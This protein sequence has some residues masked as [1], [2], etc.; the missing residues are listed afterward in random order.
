MNLTQLRSLLR[1]DL[2]DATP[3]DQRWEDDTL[4]RHLRRATAEYSLAVPWQLTLSVDTVPGSR[5]IDITSISSRVGISAVEYPAGQ[6]P[7]A[8]RR[9]ADR[10]DT[11][12]IEDGPVP[13][14]GTALIHYGVAH[15]LDDAGTT[16]PE[17]HH[18]ILLAGASAYSAIEWAVHAVNRVNT[19]ADV[20]GG[21]FRWG[22]ARLAYFQSALKTLRCGRKV[23]VGYAYNP[24]GLVS[25]FAPYLL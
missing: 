16:V 11:L 3:A 8:F 7:R 2:G 21:Y 19:G 20:A 14:G 1:L 25:S 22:S 4:N 9:F 6:E 18:E 5:E 15:L 13:D 24:E 23:R 17:K 10:A 12:F